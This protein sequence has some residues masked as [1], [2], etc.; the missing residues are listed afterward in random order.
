MTNVDM[1]V[2]NIRYV[3]KIIFGILS[4]VVAQMLNIK[5]ILWMIQ[6]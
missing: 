2:K 6:W 3:E 4:I 5:Q 1:S